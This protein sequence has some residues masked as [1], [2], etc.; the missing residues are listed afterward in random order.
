M[1]QK[2]KRKVREEAEKLA[3]EL[4]EIYAKREL[5]TRPP[6]EINEEIE[7][8]LAGTFLYEE[9]PDQTQAM[10]DIKSDLEKSEP[11]DRIICGDVG[12]G[13]TE[14]ALRTMVKAVNSGY[15]A[16]MICP[17]TI[18]ANQH[19]QNFKERLEGLPVKIAL[20]SRLQP[21]KEQRKLVEDLK[22]GKIDITIG[23][24]RILSSDVIFKNLGLLII[25]DEQRFGVK[26]KE[27]LKIQFVEVKWIKIF[28][29]KQFEHVL[30]K[31]FKLVI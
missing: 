24:H 18:L 20:L 1:W 7:N 17:T 6:Y 27:R 11:M 31:A 21:K 5:T 3:K 12:F 30:N 25:D 15:Q 14:L 23:T 8:Q 9:T 16:A 19:F 13:K 28:F 22:I 29:Y 10:G 4:L 26:Q 2:T